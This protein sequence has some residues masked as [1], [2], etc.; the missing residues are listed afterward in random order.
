MP[1]HPQVR[2]D[3]AQLIWAHRADGMGAQ[4]LGRHTEPQSSFQKKFLLRGKKSFD[5][6]AWE[7]RLRA[8]TGVCHTHTHQCHCE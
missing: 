7:Q 3:T 1:L 6:R 4:G 2:L 5:L 8:V